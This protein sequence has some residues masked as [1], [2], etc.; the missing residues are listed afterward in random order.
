MPKVLSDPAAMPTSA[1]HAI[2]KRASSVALTLTGVQGVKLT[3][4]VQTPTT[5]KEGA[6]RS[7]MN[8]WLSEGSSCIQ[9]TPGLSNAPRSAQK[10]RQQLLWAL[11][12]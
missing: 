8:V 6:L 9:H 7:H 4:S 5:Q 10:R 3:T 2:S 12:S 11:T 1:E